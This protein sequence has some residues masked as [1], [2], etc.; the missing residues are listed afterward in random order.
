MLLTLFS[1]LAYSALAGFGLPTLR[2]WLMLLLFSVFFLSNKH[3][4]AK[5][6]ILLALSW[7]YIAFSF[8][9][10][11]TEFL[12]K[13]CCCESLFVLYFGV[14]QSKKLVFLCCIILRHAQSAIMF[15]G[16]NVA[17]SGL[18]VFLYLNGFTCS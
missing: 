5:R 13:F 3:L 7:F 14:G 15:N 18:A 4:G 16:I 11:W 1:T 9:Y 17:V 2:A 8:E 12:V 6:L 10:I